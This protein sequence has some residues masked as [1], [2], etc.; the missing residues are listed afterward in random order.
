MPLTPSP[1]GE[2]SSSR[3]PPHRVSSS[4][5]FPGKVLEVAIAVE[6]AVMGRYHGA[7]LPLQ[8]TDGVKQVLV[9][10]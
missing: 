8:N 5:R 3:A 4:L 10:A 1:D 7:P 6:P 2:H 9:S